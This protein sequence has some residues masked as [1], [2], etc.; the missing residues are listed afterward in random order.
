[1]TGGGVSV[2]RDSLLA[3]Q[4]VSQVQTVLEAPIEPALRTHE[5][6]PLS[7]AAPCSHSTCDEQTQA[8]TRDTHTDTACEPIFSHFP[9][10][11]FGCSVFQMDS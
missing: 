4:P 7:A 11:R 9:S 3:V 8:R 6:P 1:M 10:T 2:R 5:Q